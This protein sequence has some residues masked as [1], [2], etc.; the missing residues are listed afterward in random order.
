MT[1]YSLSK[2]ALQ[3]EGIF[4]LHFEGRISQPRNHK[5]A[6]SKRNQG[7]LPVWFIL[8][9]RRIL[10]TDSSET[11]ADFQRTTGSYIPEHITLHKYCCENLKS[12]KLSEEC[13]F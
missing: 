2:V 10:A 13:Y 9:T 6:D 12:C 11:T 8:H 7:L 3:L 4:R 5:D 1:L